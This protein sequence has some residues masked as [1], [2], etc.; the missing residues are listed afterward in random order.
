VAREHLHR[1]RRLDLPRLALILAAALLGAT[2][3]AADLSN[4]W[5][6]VFEEPPAFRYSLL[7]TRASSGDTTRLL[8]ETATGRYELVSAQDPSDRDSMESVRALPGGETLTRRLILHGFG[9]VEGCER[10]RAPDA[11][12]ILSG[13]NGRISSGLSAFSGPDATSLRARGEALLTPGLKQSLLALAPLLPSTV[14][15]DRYGPDMLGLLWPDRFGE[16]RAKPR[17]GR[18]AAGCAFDAG[19]GYPCTAA[20]DRREKARKRRDR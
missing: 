5:H 18:R 1:G 6:F 2:A 13:P 14:E 7:F 10:V 15:L 8:L 4:R 11:C 16:R 3:S 19:F 17:I 9:N 20:E 12:V